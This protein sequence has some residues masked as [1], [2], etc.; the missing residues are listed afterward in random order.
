MLLASAET[1]PANITV[2]A[3]RAI[4][5]VPAI[6]WHTPLRSRPHCLRYAL[7]DEAVTSGHFTHSLF[8]A[9]HI[10]IGFAV[11]YEANE[12]FTGKLLSG[13]FCLTSPIGGR[14]SA[15]D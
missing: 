7:I 10:R 6:V 9:S 13:G 1:R 2:D 14:S 15:D 3:A 11:L 5:V 4:G 8:R 12:G